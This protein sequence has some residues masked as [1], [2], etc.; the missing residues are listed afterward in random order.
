[1]VVSPPTVVT[2]GQRPRRKLNVRPPAV[3]SLSSVELWSC[4]SRQ[5]EHTE[6]NRPH[7]RRSSSEVDARSGV[8][9]SWRRLASSVA[10][11]VVITGS[12]CVC[13]ITSAL[14]VFTFCNPPQRRVRMFKRQSGASLQQ[15]V[16]SQSTAGSNNTKR[17]TPWPASSTGGS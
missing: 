13:G 3:R 2:L 12:C 1:M 17:L 15:L 14:A 16:A 9:I 8:R 6:R 4:T 5:P 7:A 10:H 11:E